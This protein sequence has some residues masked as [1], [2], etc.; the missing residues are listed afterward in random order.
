MQEADSAIMPVTLRTTCR[1]C[2]S[3]N[4][5]LAVDLG[6]T[7][8][9]NS[10]ISPSD[11]DKPEEKYSLRV[12]ICTDCWFAQ[13][14]DIVNPA[15][16]FRDY[17]YFSTGV[18][19]VP[20]HFRKYAEEVI[21]KF[22]KNKEDLVVEI[23]SNDGVLIGAIQALGPRVLGVDPAV[24]IAKVA[25]DRGVKTLPEFF[26][27]DVAQKIKE[28]YGPAKVIIGNNVIAH[29]D[30]LQDVFRGVV[31]LLA[32]DGV[33]MIEAPYLKDMFD[34]L[35]FDTIYHEH[36]SYLAIQPL[37]KLLDKFGMEMFDVAI[38]P[39]QGNS[40]RIYAGKKS[41]HPVQPSVAQLADE[42][43]RIG[44]DQLSSYEKLA[45]DIAALKERIVD[46]LKKL[47]AE[48]KKISAYG[49]PAKGNTLLNYFGVGKDI[50]DY[51]TEELPSKIGLLTPGMHI[52]VIDIAD[53]RKNPP[54]YFLLLTWNTPREVILKKENDFL[55]HGGQFIV[56]V[57]R[58]TEIIKI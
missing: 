13:L 7:P 47:K 24:N 10:F 33:F 40:L 28:E 4:L 51:A 58:E 36:A 2:D 37:M 45:K 34:H 3:K 38:V 49:A 9:A 20:E 11:I 8:L 50:L 16:L 43:K 56:P 55:Q 54:D 27:A 22:A 23:G 29:I 57:G 18:A 41:A 44:M 31:A 30:G 39:V 52:P 25:N 12:F 53:A 1:A 35:R 42:E 14:V 15:I 6:K 19:S 17:I 26:N 32:D 46:L 21:A 48:G 5:V